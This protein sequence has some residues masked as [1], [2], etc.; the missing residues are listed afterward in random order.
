MEICLRDVT[1]IYNRDSDNEVRA[2]ESIDMDIKS[3]AMVCLQGPSGSGKTTL[4]SLIGCVFPP[5]SGLVSIGGKKIS[6]MSDHHLT[7]NRRSLIGYCFQ[8]Y[9][10][11]PK[12][13][14]RENIELPLL[15]MGVSPKK[16]QERSDELMERLFLSH[17]K[18]F[19]I[20]NLSGGEMQRTAIARA[21]VN[22]P[23]ILI[24]D[25]PTAH[26]D[27]K[28]AKEVLAIFAGLKEEGKTVILSSHD[29]KVVGSLSIDYIFDIRD[30]KLLGSVD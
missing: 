21:L 2:L 13:T 1:K 7:L 5:T 26:L 25:E 19:P 15:P 17:R 14:L 8:D 10:L 29:P 4:L 28:L 22:S 23:A 27:S 12:L 16:R 20:K 18:N 24:A 11:L 3:G 6:R 30:G 9:L